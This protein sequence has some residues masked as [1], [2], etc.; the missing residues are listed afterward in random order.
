MAPT[1]EQMADIGRV[2]VLA[3]K[4]G[5]SVEDY[6]ADLR[7]MVAAYDVMIV[8]VKASKSS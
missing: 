5:M 6:I 3:A 2:S 1:E 8:Y 7:A 4:H